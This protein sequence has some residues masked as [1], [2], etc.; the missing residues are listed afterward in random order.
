MMETEAVENS[1]DG[2]HSSSLFVI[3][4]CVSMMG[5]GIPSSRFC[6]IHGTCTNNNENNDEILLFP[7]NIST[8]DNDIVLLKKNL[9]TI[10][11]SLELVKLTWNP[12]ENYYFPSSSTS[13]EKFSRKFQYSW[14]GKYPWQTY[15]EVEDSAY[16]KYCVFF[17]THFA[18]HIFTV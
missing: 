8:G 17:A 13:N 6:S 10:S 5:S 9:E 11:D 2:D 1:G 7:Q 12:Y 15:P 14:F 18:G 3:D 4:N 16:Y